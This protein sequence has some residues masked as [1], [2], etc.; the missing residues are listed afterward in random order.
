MSEEHNHIAKGYRLDLGHAGQ[1]YAFIFSSIYTKKNNICL[2][3]V[4]VPEQDLS[5]KESTLMG[6]HEPIVY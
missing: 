1:G 2:L 3:P 5:K 6:K 4:H